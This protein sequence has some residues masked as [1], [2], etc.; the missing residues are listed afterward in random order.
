VGRCFQSVRDPV[1][2]VGCVAAGGYMYIDGRWLKTP[3]PKCNEGET[4]LA[5]RRWRLFFSSGLTRG[6]VRCGVRPPR[7]GRAAYGHNVAN[8]VAS[9]TIV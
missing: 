3:E 1:V 6:P 8:P 4:G 2:V 9:G 5:P 7:Q